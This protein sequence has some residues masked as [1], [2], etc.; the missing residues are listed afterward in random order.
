M[1]S[2]TKQSFLVFYSIVTNFILLLYCPWRGEEQFAIPGQPPK[3]LHPF[4]QSHT[5]LHSNLC[6][7]GPRPIPCLWGPAHHISPMPSKVTYSTKL[8][9][10]QRPYCR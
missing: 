3:T 1:E 2:V 7:H 5:N 9:S 6:G 10:L 4:P 8:R